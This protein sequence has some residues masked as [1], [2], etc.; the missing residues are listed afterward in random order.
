MA[1]IRY[2]F[3]LP[4]GVHESVVLEFDDQTFLLR[5]PA[6]QGVEAWTALDFHICPHCPLDK[7]THPHCPLARALAGFVH[8]FDRFYSYEVAEVEVQAGSRRIISKQPLQAAMASILGLVGATSGCPHLDFFR[9]MARFHLP[10]A[11]E[12]ETLFRALSIHLLGE[13]LRAGGQGDKLVGVAGL[14]ARYAAVADVNLTM[15]DRIRAAFKKDVVVNA[16]V[17]L[18]TF[19]QAVPWVIDDA[20]LELRPLFDLPDPPIAGS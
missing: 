3:H 17:I 2:T 7:R 5:P 16:I 13:Y 11:S 15:A 8:E 10:F 20:L 18:D 1:E 19:A 12:Q 4:D 6:I 14:Q 9:P